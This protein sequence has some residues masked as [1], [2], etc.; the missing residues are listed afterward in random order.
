ME[1]WTK[2]YETD[3]LQ[4]A[5]LLKSVLLNEGIEAVTLNQK[6]SSYVVYGTISIYVPNEMAEQAN[7]IIKSQLSSE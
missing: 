3:D 4:N 7:N 2:V 5:E 6:D 1:N